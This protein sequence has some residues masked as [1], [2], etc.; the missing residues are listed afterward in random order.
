[1]RHIIAKTTTYD[2]IR[3][4]ITTVTAYEDRDGLGTCFYT[5]NVDRE[6]VGNEEYG[7]FVTWEFDTMA[8]ALDFMAGQSGQVTPT[9]GGVS[10]FKD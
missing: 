1:M 4:Q 2:G 9:N 5:V 3:D 10:A 6:E 7:R 8:K